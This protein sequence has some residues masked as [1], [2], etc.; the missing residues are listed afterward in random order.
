MLGMVEDKSFEAGPQRFSSG[1]KYC[2]D[3]PR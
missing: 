1:I 3:L 2:T